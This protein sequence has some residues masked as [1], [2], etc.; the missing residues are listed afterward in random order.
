MPEDYKDSSLYRIR[1][2]TAHVMA[3]AM[4]ERF[5]EARIAIGPPIE[6]G[7]YY[8]FDL[9]R[10][11]NEEDVAWVEARMKDIIRGGYAFQYREVTADEARAQ[12]AEEPYKLELIDELASGKFDENGNPLSAPADK[13][14]FY[15]QDT[16]TDLCRGPH[17]ANTSEI[18]ADAISISFKAPAGAYWRGD[19]KREQL[20]RIYGTAWE[21]ARAASGVP[22]P[23]RRGQAPRSSRGR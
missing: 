7:F 8:D 11:I 15:T 18:D 9:P 21:I 16:F 14:S 17:V 1:H 20:T 4:I 6:D 13:I 3:Q 12:F 19:E 23:A 5:P 10:A 2:S 22:A